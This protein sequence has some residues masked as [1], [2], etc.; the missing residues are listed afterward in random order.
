MPGPTPSGLLHLRTWLH[1]DVDVVAFDD[2]CD[3]HQVDQLVVPGVRRVRR[4]SR[5]RTA[6]GTPPDSLT[7]YDLDHLDVLAS[8]EHAELRRRSTGL[9]DAFAGR[10]RA[11]RCEAWLVEGVPAAEGLGEGEAVAQLYVAEGDDLADWFAAEGTALLDAAGGSLARLHHGTGEEQ[12][13]LVE[14]GAAA[15]PDPA[16]LPVPPAELLG[17]DPEASW[18]TY[19]LDFAATPDGRARSPHRDR[20]A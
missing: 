1:P 4:F 8:A 19:R 9:P 5:W 7:M 14:L 10:L 3:G 11:A 2:W 12:I 6:G 17:G 20:R 16:A 13:V 15:D 18:G